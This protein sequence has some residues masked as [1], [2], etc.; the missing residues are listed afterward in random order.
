M[1]KL[2]F[3]FMFASSFAF[4][5]THAQPM[6][7]PM[8]QQPMGQPGQHRP[9]PKVHPAQPPAAI[10]A[11]AEPKDKEKAHVEEEES[12]P[13]VKWWDTQ[14]LNNKQPP[15]AALLFN[16][17]ILALIYYRYGKKPLADGLKNRKISIATAIENAQRILREAK[18][19]SKRYRSKLDKVAADA[20]QGK[21]SL[22]STGQG[23]AEMIR[24]TADEK[25][26][27]IERDATFL[28]EQE[29][30]QTQLDLVRE[31]VEKAAREAEAL[32]K[33]NVSTADQERL[34]DEFLTRL[35]ADYEKGLPL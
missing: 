1:K 30:K 14:I 33:S 31:T 35:T 32:L 13:P 24:R 12:L 34:A 5:Q 19:R 20:E 2:V 16:F 7:Q 17:A 4:A 29:K 6:G 26:A 23:E 9:R 15:I 3:A 21:A 27:R 8:G 22:V 28:L 10:S 11:A 25:A 18:E